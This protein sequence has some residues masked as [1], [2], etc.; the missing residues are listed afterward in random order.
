MP[1]STCR[2]LVIARRFWPQVDDAVY[3][4]THWLVAMSACGYRP[5]LLTPRW[6]PSW[7]DKFLFRGFEVNRLLPPPT[8]N[9]N[10]GNFCRN[11]VQWIQKYGDAFDAIYCDQADMILPHIQSK[12]SSWSKPIFVRFSPETSYDGVPFGEAGHR[13]IL[14]EPLRKCETI[15]VPTPA[16]HRLLIS[17]GIRDLHIQ[18]IVDPYWVRIKRSGERKEEVISA[19]AKVSGD[20]VLPKKTLLILHVGI[21]Q[22]KE[23][24][25]ALESICDLLENCI[26][27][28]MWIINPGIPDSVIY[29]YVKDRGFHREILVFNGFDDIEDLFAIADL[30][31]VSNPEEL[32]QFTLPVLVASGIC[33][34][35]REH[36]DLSQIF[37]EVTDQVTYNSPTSLALRLH[38]W[39]ANPD[40]FRRQTKP[41][42]NGY[43]QGA[44][45]TLCLE[46]WGRLLK[47]RIGAAES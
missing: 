20:F 15:I 29:D 23:L 10:E 25:T 7:P 38:H 41:I 26:G 40:S 18:R 30:V 4:L 14:L 21:S 44:S 13:G 33:V 9:W 43:L 36:P 37:G 3:R 34:I 12:G 39:F 8:T 42:R 22:W 19:L 31:W 5:T 11:V 1:Q 6:H 17:K 28:R 16:P 32:M 45:P 47:Q 27:L 24:K 2:L 46:H 35:A